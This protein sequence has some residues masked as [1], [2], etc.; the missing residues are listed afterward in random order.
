MLDCQT[1]S[2][3]RQTAREENDGY[4]RMVTLMGSGK[5]VT[6]EE[7]QRM[8]EAIVRHLETTN[9]KITLGQLRDH[10]VS[11]PVDKSDK[12]FCVAE[13]QVSVS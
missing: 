13:S 9:W 7:Q 3:Q 1:L 5:E 10:L 11:G 6:A 4:P 8:A 2:G 12:H